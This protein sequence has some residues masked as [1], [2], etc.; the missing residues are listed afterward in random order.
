MQIT[1]GPKKSRRKC[2]LTLS[3]PFFQ[4]EAEISMVLG[5]AAQDGRALGP[6]IAKLRNAP[7][8]PE[9]P[10]WIVGRARNSHVLS[11]KFKDSI[12]IEPNCYSNKVV[13]EEVIK[14]PWPLDQQAD[15]RQSGVPHSPHLPLECTAASRSHASSCFKV[16]ATTVREW[17]AVELVGL[18]LTKPS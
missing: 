16:M 10:H 15:P 11:L 5:L 7:C 17:G 8:L 18:Y 9:H 12:V 3:F 4:W 13:L 6:P 2:F 1:S 14:K